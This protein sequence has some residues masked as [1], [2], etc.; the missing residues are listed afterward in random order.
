MA[1]ASN[2]DKMLEAVL[3]DLDLMKFGKYTPSE[4][5]SVY[6][7]VSV[8]LLKLFNDHLKEQQRKKFIRK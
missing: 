5:T 8:Q 3:T 4:I 6:Q 1:Y 2:N 7:A